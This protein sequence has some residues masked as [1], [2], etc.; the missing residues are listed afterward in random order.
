MQPIH[1]SN[2]CWMDDLGAAGS[3]AMALPADG[4][5]ASRRVAPGL[6]VACLVAAT[7][8]AGWAMTRSP[9]S[10]QARVAAATVVTAR[11]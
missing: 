2:T 3:A 8:L 1:V 11:R 7:S 5:K 6:V 9:S 10:P 4:R